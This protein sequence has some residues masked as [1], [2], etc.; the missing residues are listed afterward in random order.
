MPQFYVIGARTVAERSEAMET[1]SH[2]RKQT[3]SNFAEPVDTNVNVKDS[4]CR[5]SHTST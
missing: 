5:G 1:V 4:L 2:L 3:L